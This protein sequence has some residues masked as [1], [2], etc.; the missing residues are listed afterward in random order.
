MNAISASVWGHPAGNASVA[1]RLY[2]SVSSRRDAPAVS[3]VRVARR[4]E[5]R[6]TVKQHYRNT[7]DFQ[8][9]S[10]Y[11]GAKGSRVLPL[12]GAPRFL[13]WLSFFSKRYLCIFSMPTIQGFLQIRMYSTA[14]S[15]GLRPQKPRL[16]G[17]RKQSMKSWCGIRDRQTWSSMPAP[18][19]AGGESGGAS[20]VLGFCDV[21]L[22]PDCRFD[23]ICPVQK[24]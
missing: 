1:S 11:S 9:G 10:G 14:S 20:A 7:L 17:F 4:G 8:Q 6:R 3:P 2:V 23:S 22:H 12:C 13:A 24:L 19:G 16:S 18:S 21:P 5:F 15:R